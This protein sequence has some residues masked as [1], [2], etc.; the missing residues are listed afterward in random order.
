[1]KP[2]CA[3]SFVALIVVA[4]GGPPSPTA[5]PSSNA[6]TTA[7]PTI[8]AL[9]S[10]S[11]E[12]NELLSGSEPLAP[13][14]YTRT[15]FQPAITFALEEGWFAGTLA[16]DFFDVQQDRNTPDVIAVQFGVIESVVGA[17]GAT[18]AATS[19]ADV[20]QAIA[21]NPGLELLSESESRMSGMT[22]ANLEVENST[23]SHT[24]ILDVSLGRLGIDPG[25]R[26]WISLFDT[27]DGV[28]A[29]MV[30]GSVAQWD[31]A[32]ALAEPVLESVVIGAPS[33]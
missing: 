17:D 3:A 24:G 31:R 23:T 26:L 10:P 11:G 30:G 4:C 33:E 32:L 25:R 29:I 6:A 15:G 1:V 7:T 22:G 18:E 27:D 13:G 21:K 5:A 28:L 14:R 12:V 16:S 19:A 20:A 8:E 9:E 2:L